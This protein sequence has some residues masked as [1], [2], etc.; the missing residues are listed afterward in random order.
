MARTWSTVRTNMR[1][2]LDTAASGGTYGDEL[3]TYFNEAQYWLWPLLPDIAFGQP[4]RGITVHEITSTTT[5][6][7]VGK[8]R[9]AANMKTLSVR[10]ATSNQGTPIYRGVEWLEGRGAL[11]AKRGDSANWVAG[12]NSCFAARE[13][14]Y[15]YFGPVVEGDTLTETWIK[16]PTEVTSGNST[17]WTCDLP[18][19]YVGIVEDKA[20]A[21]AL[22]QVGNANAPLWETKAQNGVAAVYARLNLQPP[23]GVI[24]RPEVR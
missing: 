9:D 7:I 17:T 1:S 4:S 14:D 11:Y 5:D 12:L 19:A 2:K 15:I 18:D 13:L 24:N 10:Y 6:G 3:M 22:A 16:W 20:V 8:A 23:P 21:T